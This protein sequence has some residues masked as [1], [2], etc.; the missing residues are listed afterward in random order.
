MLT[1]R[2]IYT[3]DY[4]II[5]VRFIMDDRT[6]FLS[7]LRETGEQYGVSIVCL[8]R[9]MMAGFSH[10]ETTLVHA[11]RSWKEGK[12]IARSLEIEVLLYAAGTRQTGQIGPFGPDKG[13]NSCYLCIIPPS[14]KVVTVLLTRMKEIL[15]EDWND[16]DEEKIKRLSNFFGITPEELSVT[17]EEKIAELVCE[18]SALLT[19][20]H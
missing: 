9:N 8:N 15:D 7:Y 18:R 20:N 2:R 10:V 12:Q 17:G 1:N 6:S 5:P 13:E 11:I 4:C 16:L 14:E 19:V 3:D